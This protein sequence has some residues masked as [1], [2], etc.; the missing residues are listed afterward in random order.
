DFLLKEL[1]HRQRHDV[2]EIERLVARL[3]NDREARELAEETLGMERAHLEAVEA[4]LG[5]PTGSP[6]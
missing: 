6:G 3:A 5:Q 1:H 4:L 2:A